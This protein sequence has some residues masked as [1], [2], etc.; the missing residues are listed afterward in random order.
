MPSIMY[1]SVARSILKYYSSGENE[2]RAKIMT[3][4]LTIKH[5]A[6]K[7][8]VILADNGSFP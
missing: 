8:I 6:N 3:T 2:I 1:S 7:L 5:N 4:N